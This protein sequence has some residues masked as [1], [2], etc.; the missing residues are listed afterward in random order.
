MMFYLDWFAGIVCQIDQEEAAVF[1]LTMRFQ[2]WS[3]DIPRAIKSLH[4]TYTGRL[5]VKKMQKHKQMWTGTKI[6]I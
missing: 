1:F 4:S 5:T 6:V 3:C 2:Q